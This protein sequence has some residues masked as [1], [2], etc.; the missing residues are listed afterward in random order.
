[1]TGREGETPAV[2]IPVNGG[3]VTASQVR[4]L[5][6]VIERENAARGVF[7]TL[8]EPTAPM[9]KE[10]AAAEFWQTAA[11]AAASTP[12]CRSSASKPIAPEHVLFRAFRFGFGGVLEGSDVLL[13][14][15]VDP[16]AAQ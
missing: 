14:G 11:S 8:Q 4:D 9:R 2:I 15:H 12:A 3:H 13:G 16:R 5:R 7:M 6:G 1:M 10:A